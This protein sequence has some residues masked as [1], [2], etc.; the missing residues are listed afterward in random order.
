MDIINKDTPCSL[1]VSI[2]RKGRTI[3]VVEDIVMVDRTFHTAPIP[4]NEKEAT[5]D[6]DVYAP[7]PP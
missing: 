3:K 5:C 4:E 7:P 2:R 6:D 1:H